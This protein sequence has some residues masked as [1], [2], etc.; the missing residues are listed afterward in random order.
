MRLTGFFVV[1]KKCLFL[2]FLLI[3]IEYDENMFGFFFC[4]EKN[5]I[6]ATPK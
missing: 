2:L 5:V 4:N 1:R 3:F 6:F